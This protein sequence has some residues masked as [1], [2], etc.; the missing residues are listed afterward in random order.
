M[1]VLN[2][3]SFAQARE[4]RN[5]AWNIACVF[6]TICGVPIF[7]WFGAPAVTWLLLWFLSRWFPRWLMWFVS[8][9]VSAQLSVLL[10]WSWGGTF[11]LAAGT[12]ATSYLPTLRPSWLRWVAELGWGLVW[13]V[14]AL[15]YRSQSLEMTMF[16]LLLGASTLWLFKERGEP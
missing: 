12:V 9:F 6:G 16:I 8:F 3:W 2:R 5:L 1:S 14:L 10:G 7:I 11:I 13:F 4:W 15:L